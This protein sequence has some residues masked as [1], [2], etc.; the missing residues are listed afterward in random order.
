MDTL[1]AGAKAKHVNFPLFKLI[2]IFSGRNFIVAPP[3]NTNATAATAVLATFPSKHVSSIE[4]ASA[5]LWPLM[6]ARIALLSAV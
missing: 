3:S 2:I 5:L 6:V 1:V 4:Y